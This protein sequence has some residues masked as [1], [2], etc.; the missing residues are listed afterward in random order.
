MKAIVVLLA[1]AIFI[2][3]VDTPRTTLA[4]PRMILDG[5]SKTTRELQARITLVEKPGINGT[6]SLV[7]VPGAAQRRQFRRPASGFAAAGKNV[8]FE[9][10]DADGKVV[11]EGWLLPR[12]GRHADPGA[13]SLPHDSSIRGG[14]AL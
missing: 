13:I 10:V 3:A 12:G 4:E 6:R 1:G 14:H 2:S 5:W 8:K 7:P 9:L 11:R